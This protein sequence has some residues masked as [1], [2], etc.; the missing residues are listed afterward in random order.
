MP[1]SKQSLCQRHEYVA[2]DILDREL[3][4]VMAVDAAKQRVTS[5]FNG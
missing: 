4:S 1:L 2:I 3:A 5:L